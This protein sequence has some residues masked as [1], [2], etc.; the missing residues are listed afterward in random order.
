MGKANTDL[1]IARPY[2][3]FGG[4]RYGISEPPKGTCKLPDGI[5]SSGKQ[6]TKPDQGS[7]Q[8]REENSQ[9]LKGFGRS[10]E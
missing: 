5:R 9:T 4:W 3:G 1:G 10:L 7:S 6:V 8:F 2:V